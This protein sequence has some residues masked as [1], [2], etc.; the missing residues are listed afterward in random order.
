MHLFSEFPPASKTDWLAKIQ[1]DLKGKSINDLFYKVGD[2]QIAPFLSKIDL[3]E[4][5]APLAAGRETNHWDINENISVKEDFKLANSL[6]LKALAGGASALCFEV[7]S[8]PKATNLAILLKDIELDYIQTSFLEKTRNQNPLSFLK[9][10]KQYI[11][12]TGKNPA[13]IRGSVHFDPFADG[14]QD[15]KI[16]SE[17]V[18]WATE[19]LPRFNVITV[20]ETFQ[21]NVI[22]SLTDLFNAATVYL[23]K[24]SERGIDISKIVNAMQFSVTVGTKFFIDIAKIR[25]LKILWGN[26]LS[27]YGVEPTLPFLVADTHNM[28][29]ITNPHTPKIQAATQAM[30]ATI[31]GINVL[32][33]TPSDAFSDAVRGESSDFNRRIARNVQH[34]LQAESGFTHVIDPAA[35]SY[36]VETLT[37]QFCE[38]IWKKLNFANT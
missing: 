36:F 19:N 24:I 23:D 35:G 38:T 28:P 25:T 29:N 11:E 9:N 21:E 8:F 12:K 6:A 14:H 34:L 4:K 7:E 30:A 22:E 18:L 17:L 3:V 15:I 2:L 13:E 26:I 20:R 1:K 33:V 31:G 10:L 37:Q 5:M 27:A 16:A 32:T